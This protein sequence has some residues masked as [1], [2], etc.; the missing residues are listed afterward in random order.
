[1]NTPRILTFLQ[2]IA[3]HNS[4]EWMQENKEEYTA[5][6]AEFEGFVDEAIAQIA[7]FDDTIAHLTAKDCTYR[8]NRDTR[9]SQDKSPY[10]THL[11]AYIAA[12]GKK[13]LHAGYYLHLEPGK[14]LL[15]TGAYWL[16]TNILTAMRNEIMGNLEEW[17]RCVEN[18]DFVN[19]YGKANAGTWPDDNPSPKGFG[20]SCLK[21]APKG[22]PKDYPYLHYLKMKDYCAW[23]RV[24]DTFFD[25]ADW[26]TRMTEMFTTAK[27]MMD[28][29]NSVI[30]DYE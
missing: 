9:F 23:H 4:R 27:P 13:A 2:N 12:H 21:T 26:K 30:D 5:C 3:A 22:F 8:F 14:C 10:K 17:Q 7:T 6:R 29:I 18:P 11:G 20:I 28:F 1:M 24:D 25:Q 19:L 15:A 16:P